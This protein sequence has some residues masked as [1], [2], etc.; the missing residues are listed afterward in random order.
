VGNSFFYALFVFLCYQ[1]VRR[2]FRNNR[3]TQLSLSSADS[4][5]KDE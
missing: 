2:A 5:K 1:P 3:P 4:T